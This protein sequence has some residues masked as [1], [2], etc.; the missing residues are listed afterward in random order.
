MQQIV[1]ICDECG[2]RFEAEE[3]LGFKEAWEQAKDE[4]WI[5]Y[6]KDGEWIHKCGECRG[7]NS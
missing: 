3:G 2:D 6:C 7:N 1:Y 5:C 4:D